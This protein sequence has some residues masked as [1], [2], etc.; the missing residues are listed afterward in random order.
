MVLSKNLLIAFSF[1]IFFLISNVHCIDIIPGTG[2]KMSKI[3]Y[4]TVSCA[5]DG[6]Q[7]RTF[8]T[9]FKATGVCISEACCCIFRN[10]ILK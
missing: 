9:G 8:C 7:C 4:D 5:G 3:C 6:A 10:K 2:I 1:A